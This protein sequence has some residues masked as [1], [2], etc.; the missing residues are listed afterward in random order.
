M[1]PPGILVLFMA[2]A[3]LGARVRIEEHG[4]TIQRDG[5]LPEWSPEEARTLGE[6]TTLAWDALNTPEGLAGYVRF[7]PRS[8]CSSWTV[9]FFPDMRA[10]QRPLAMRVDTA[11]EGWFYSVYEWEDD[12][13]GMLSA[14]WVIP[15]DTIRVDSTGEYEIGMYA[16]SACGD[17]LEPVILTGNRAAREGTRGVFGPGLL[18]RIAIVAALLVLYLVLQARARK[19]YLGKG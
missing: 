12:T 11:G 8:A 3:V 5:F 19:K 15:W 9:T 7:S 4:R 17:T 10:L 6:D 14:E 2:C 13:T 1:A 18:A 16:A